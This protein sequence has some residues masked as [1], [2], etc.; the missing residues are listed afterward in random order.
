MLWTELHPSEIHVGILISNVTIY[1]DGV[2]EEVIKV[3]GSHRVGS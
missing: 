1:G 3:K 2:Y